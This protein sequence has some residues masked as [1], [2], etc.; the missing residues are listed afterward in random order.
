MALLLQQGIGAEKAAMIVTHTWW[1]GLI[2]GVGSRWLV[3]H[4]GNKREQ[5]EA[6]KAALG[7]MQRKQAIR[8]TA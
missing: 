3:G 1:L 8:M 6:L 2:A 4:G 5:Y 7:V